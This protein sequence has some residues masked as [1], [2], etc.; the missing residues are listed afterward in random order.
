MRTC[1]PRRARARGFTLIELMVVLAIAGIMFAALAQTLGTS[2]RLYGTA[3]AYLRSDDDLHRSLD[4]IC[5]MLR[6]AMM[7]TMD[8]IPAIVESDG[9]TGITVDDWRDQWA[10]Q[11][12]FKWPSDAQ[13]VYLPGDPRTLRWRSAAPVNGITSPGEVVHEML[14]VTTVVAPR[15]PAGGFKIR[16]VG[17]SSLEVMLST[18]SSTAQRTNAITTASASVL[19]RNP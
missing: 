12:T 8:P 6:G 15:V 10:T 19:V 9:V 16:R 4:A 14:G 11:L 7:S 1:S 13:S 17:E 2:T 18:Y 3:R 5:G